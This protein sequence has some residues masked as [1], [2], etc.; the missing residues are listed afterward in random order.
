ML[1]I[2]FATKF[3]VDLV[4]IAI[5]VLFSKF[6]LSLFSSYKK[7]VSHV[8]CSWRKQKILYCKDSII[9]KSYLPYYKKVSRSVLHSI[10]N[11]DSQGIEV[12]IKMMK[13]VDIRKYIK[14]LGGKSTRNLKKI[15][16]V[17]ELQR[18][19]TTTN[20]GVEK[21]NLLSILN[22][23]SKPSSKLDPPISLV[24]N[25]K[26]ITQRLR[27]MSPI[28]PSLDFNE[29]VNVG[30]DYEELNAINSTFK[31]DPVE[32]FLNPRYR[33]TTKASN[34]TNYVPNGSNS[35]VNSLFRNPFPIGSNRD[36]RFN[37]VSSGFDMD[38][39]FL[40]TASCIP[41]VTRG[42]SSIAFRFNCSILLT[43]GIYLSKYIYMLE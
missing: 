13:L 12:D 9:H 25:G 3:K 43:V 41:S 21:T 2:P 7:Q 27:N 14:L 42:V 23:S 11:S 28:R 26:D 24:K 10:K 1:C 6:A 35:S 31:I 19:L 38:M 34:R 36:N 18:L 37:E 20:D 39:T 5:F 17:T 16:V 32:S 8:S 30:L 4:L 15:E 22:N 29:G 40:G 33:K